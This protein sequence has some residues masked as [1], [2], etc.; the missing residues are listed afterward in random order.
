MLL[1]KQI[2]CLSKVKCANVSDIREDFK[3]DFQFSFQW[4][5]LCVVLARATI[6]II[7]I[8]KKST[9]PI[10]L[11]SKYNLRKDLI[12]GLCVDP[13]YESLHLSMKYE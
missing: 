3:N 10:E 7:L 6:K 4:G 13:V 2:L 12:S 8:E 5:L 11:L 9:W 1:E